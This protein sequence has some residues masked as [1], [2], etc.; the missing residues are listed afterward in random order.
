MSAVRHRILVVDDE[1]NMRRVLEIMLQRMGYFVGV[2]EN[3]EQ[4]L[5]Q[6]HDTSFDLV[7]SDLRM[8]TLDGGQLLRRLREAGND[9]PFIIVT[10]HGSVESAVAALRGGADDYILRPFDIDALK[11][12]LDRIFA[13]QHM[14]RQNDFLRAELE[15]GW[16]GMIGPSAAMR[17]VYEKVRLVAPNKTSVMIT[18][19]TGTGK[20]LVARAV[21]QASPRANRLFVAVNCAAIPGEMIESELFGYDKGAFTGAVKDRIGKFELAS[22]GTL[23]LDELSEMPLALQAKLLRVL[24][25]GVVERL[26]SNVAIPLDLRVI[27]AT[28]RDPRQAIA[29]GRLREDLYY[30]INVFG[31]HLPPLRQRREDVPELA[32]HFLSEISTAGPAAR[33]FT[34]EALASLQHYDWPGNVR[35]LRN[36]IE[37]AAVLA[38]GG[39]IELKHLALEP[40]PGGLAVL[41][42]K[43]PSD[44]GSAGDLDLNKAVDALESR[45]VAE[46]LR[47]TGG[48]KTRA[49]ELLNISVRSLWHKLGKAGGER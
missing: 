13:A 8:P 23:F 19:E 34:E 44:L 20:E 10:A 41:E 7:I 39:V 45:Y 5:E 16:G 36:V 35:E 12:A 33:G 22:G 42:D 4:A 47:R 38:G 1:Q 49:A 32:K 31:I 43:D 3:G 25:E 27:A 28:N 24:Q 2:A 29:D 37:R 14:R 18:G 21:H 26:G 30:R 6:L 9:V 17:E 15:R 11:L 48:N 40:R 46:A